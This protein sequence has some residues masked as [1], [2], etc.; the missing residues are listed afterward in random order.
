[1]LCFTFLTC[2][3]P[4]CLYVRVFLCICFRCFIFSIVKKVF[5]V[6]FLYNLCPG[7]IVDENKIRANNYLLEKCCF[8]NVWMAA[9]NDY[10]FKLCYQIL[11]FISMDILKSD[12]FVNLRW[13]WLIVFTRNI[14]ISLN[15][16][17]W[18][19][20]QHHLLFQFLF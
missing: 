13:L 5:G 16:I 15:L 14:F 3:V 12:G 9:Y 10:D 11:T 1:M 2:F 4:V 7:V 6:S 20:L 17:D 8:K 18:S 19:H